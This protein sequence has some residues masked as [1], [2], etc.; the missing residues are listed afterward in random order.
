MA[1]IL[2]EDL[3]SYEL[4]LRVIAMRNVMAKEPS[5]DYTMR[6]INR[7]YSKEFNT[8]LHLVEALPRHDILLHY[9]ESVYLQLKDDDKREAELN[10]TIQELIN[11]K[12]QTKA[13]AEKVEA[14][15]FEKLIEE[16]E[17]KK[18][19]EPDKPKLIVSP[20]DLDEDQ[21]VSI[22]FQDL[23]KLDELEGKV[24]PLVGLK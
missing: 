3:P 24:E 23:N 14:Y 13:E 21:P 8:P 15:E 18:V 4:S 11:P 1:D 9:Y 7:W 6:Y 16:Q 17:A 22:N 10:E 5:N 12:D 2:Q 20:I 19:K